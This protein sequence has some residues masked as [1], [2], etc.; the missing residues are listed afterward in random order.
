MENYS[1]LFMQKNVLEITDEYDDF[2][3][4]T[5]SENDNIDK[6]LITF[7]NP[8]WSNISVSFKFHDKDND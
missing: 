3:N 7:I 6:N 1:F 4:S 8:K 2:I 5:D